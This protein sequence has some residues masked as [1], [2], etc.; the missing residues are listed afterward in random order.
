MKRS[1]VPREPPAWPAQQ[2]L[3]PAPAEAGSSRRPFGSRRGGCGGSTT[4][5]A[6]SCSPAAPPLP[7]QASRGCCRSRAE[8]AGSPAEP[9]CRWPWDVGTQPEEPKQRD[10]PQETRPGPGEPWPRGSDSQQEPNSRIMGQR[11]SDK[12]DLQR[13][14]KGDCPLIKGCRPP[15][16]CQALGLLR[17]GTSNPTAVPPPRSAFL[18]RGTRPSPSLP[19]RQLHL[20]TRG[21][22][23]SWCG[24]HRAPR[25][26]WRSPSSRPGLVPKGSSLSMGRHSSLGGDYAHLQAAPLHQQGLSRMGGGSHARW[27]HHAGWWHI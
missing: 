15:A 16:A 8:P 6:A 19:R 24:G 10:K 20:P 22:A 14:D 13:D 5:A 4:L 12:A 7:S 21:P 3:L 23:G 27:R 2:A 17:P 25:L 11:W 26:G 9:R 1:L 18:F